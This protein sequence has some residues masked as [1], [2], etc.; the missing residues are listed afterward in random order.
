MLLIRFFQA[1][2]ANLIFAFR[3]F[4][5]K[6]QLRSR[7]AAVERRI[8]REFQSIGETVYSKRGDIAASERQVQELGH[9]IAELESQK[10]ALG[11][12]MAALSKTRPAA[13]LA[14]GETGYVQRGEKSIR[15]RFCKT[16]LSASARYCAVCGKRLLL[17][18]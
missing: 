7:L 1:G 17:E 4:L 14:F 6:R 3:T 5:K 2:F 16:T 12:E 10:Q 15:C 18:E 11:Q 13:L 9:A 8:A